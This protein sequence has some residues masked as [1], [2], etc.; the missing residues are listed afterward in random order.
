MDA[1]NF[2]VVI[3]GGGPA[4]LVL[5]ME[6][7]RRSVSCL[8]VDDKP[9]TTT[10]P[11]ANA[12][13]ART[14]EHYRR[15]GFVHEIRP[16]GLPLDYPTDMVCCTRLARHELA[17]YKRPSS[18]QAAQSV[19][20]LTGSWSTPELPHRCA[21]I[22]VEPILLKHARKF[23]SVEVQHNWR[24]TRF[25]EASD[26]VEVD[27]ERVDGTAQRAVRA[28]YFVGCEGAKTIARRQLG[29]KM[30][31]ELTSAREWM[32][33]KMHTI[34]FRSPKLYEVMGHPTAWM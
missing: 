15:L 5:A 26:H 30:Q 10:Q 21:L 32:A 14:M 18:K 1:E 8:L 22:F 7:G 24:A 12:T 25:R 3:A 4:G 9:G 31:G 6:L 17:R 33:G 11:R 28:K 34:Y 16:L 19:R 13:Q 29:I 20:N 2:D 27:I 23:P